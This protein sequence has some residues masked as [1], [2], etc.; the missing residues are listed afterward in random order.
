MKHIKLYQKDAQY[1]EEAT[2]S[3]MRSGVFPLP[4]VSYTID[5]QKIYYNPFTEIADAGDV[6]VYDSK[7]QTTYVIKS[8]RYFDEYED[9]DT[10]TPIGVVVV[11]ADHTDD[12]KCRVIALKWCSA[13]DPEN[14]STSPTNIYWGCDTNIDGLEVFPSYYD[15]YLPNEKGEYAIVDT[16]KQAPSPYNEDGSK[17]TEYPFTDFDGAYNTDKII[18][19]QTV[20]W[21]GATITNN[22]NEG[23]YPL[24]CCSRRYHTVGTNAGDY[25]IPSVGEIGYISPKYTTI[26]TTFKKLTGKNIGNMSTSTLYDNY[27]GALGG[28][29]N[30]DG[31]WGLG[32]Y[33]VYDGGGNFF[34]VP[35]TRISPT[36][37]I[38]PKVGMY[39]YDDGT[40]GTEVKTGHIVGV[41]AIPA[42]ATPD[43]KVRIIP[44]YGAVN[45]IRWGDIEH[46]EIG[47]LETASARAFPYVCK[48]GTV[49][50][51]VQGVYQNTL[52][53]SYKYPLIY[54]EAP[55][56]IKN[57][58]GGESIESTLN[59]SLSI[60]AYNLSEQIS[61]GQ[62]DECILPVPYLADGSI[63]PN[64]AVDGTIT[65]EWASSE[66]NMEKMS[67]VN[68]VF[69]YTNEFSNGIPAGG[70]HVPSITE[71]ILMMGKMKT[72]VDAFAAAGVRSPFYYIEN[73]EFY[74]YV[75]SSSYFG[76]WDD[77]DTYGYALYGYV[78]FDGTWGLDYGRV[79][80]Y[81]DYYFCL[82]VA[83]V[84]NDTAVT[85]PLLTDYPEYNG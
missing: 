11:P 24:A 45:N 39:Y 19:K 66:A 78:L 52:G 71:V 17:N 42:A 46:S 49:Y 29:V 59:P 15:M 4:N 64:F 82:P 48:D 26:N 34:C 83:S 1:Q 31:G 18:A 14:G 85:A 57:L 77:S 3:R 7:L 22:V 70:W 62:F 56:E 72:I 21:S 2:I 58:Y 81:D 10:I 63:N 60:Y 47:E 28:I 23:N 16:T 35:F 38:S 65:N 54:I 8:Q 73:E 43:N 27:G 69:K 79:D 12:G 55:D 33:Y 51:T 76:K 68:G 13:T 9:D 40:F 30:F 32:Y 61:D 37:V 75:W 20:D 53:G 50:E 6:A 74:G 36:P 41:V 5:T 80:D 25:Y 67:H 44:L 84:G